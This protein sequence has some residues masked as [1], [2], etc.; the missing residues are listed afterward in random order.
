[1]RT[2][3]RLNADL[4]NLGF[5]GSAHMEDAMADYIAGR[6]DWDFATVEMGINVIDRWDPSRFEER[7]SSFISKIVSA[8]PGKP[9]F[10]IDLFFS[11]YDLAQDPKVGA[12]RD[13]VS[14][15]VE[16][17]RSPHAVYVNGRELLR[18]VGELSADLLHPSASGHEAIALRL[19]EKIRQV[20]GEGPDERSS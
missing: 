7:I 20:A 8:H 15:Q 12:Y 4:I 10:F 17:H 18:D 9:V 2:A 16:R 11:K 3:R 1:M 13:A 6:Q 14:R 19:A 5:A